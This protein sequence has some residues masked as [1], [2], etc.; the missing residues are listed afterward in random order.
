V[1][2]DGSYAGG[3]LEE[4]CADPV[5]VSIRT[6]ESIGGVHTGRHVGKR[7]TELGNRREGGYLYVGILGGL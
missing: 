1:S 5:T 2:E 3:I 4:S 7:E 6:G